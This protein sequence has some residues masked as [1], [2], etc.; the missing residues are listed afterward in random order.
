MKKKDLAG[1]TYAARI[2]EE[3]NDATNES[4]VEIIQVS[5]SALATSDPNLAIH[6]LD[7]LI[8]QRQKIEELID[9]REQDAAEFVKTLA[10][11]LPA[12]I[13]FEEDEGNEDMN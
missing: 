3:T 4:L 11:N 6:V 10:D 5:F 12:V 8:P 13:E 9:E 7:Q 1:L 2:L